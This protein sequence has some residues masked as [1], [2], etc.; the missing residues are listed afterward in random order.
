MTKN[1]KNKTYEGSIWL[2]KKYFTPRSA[3]RGMFA[4]GYWHP[5]QRTGPK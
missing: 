3:A 5:N 4:G 1:L 2:N